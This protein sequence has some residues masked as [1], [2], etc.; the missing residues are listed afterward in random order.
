MS[1]N[2]KYLFWI[3]SVLFLCFTFWYGYLSKM[4]ISETKNTL[5]LSLTFSQKF[6]AFIFIAKNNLMVAFAISILGFISGGT[7]TYMVLGWNSY[8]MGIVCKW[9]FL[10]FS[11]PNEIIFNHILPHGILEILSFLLFSQIGLKGFMFYRHILNHNTFNP[12]LFPKI[13]DFINPSLLLLISALIES[14]ISS[15]L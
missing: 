7:I 1:T 13:R 10:N 4:G 8:M 3:F 2:F 5:A 15:S 12:N 14:F 6:Q 11:N 9:L